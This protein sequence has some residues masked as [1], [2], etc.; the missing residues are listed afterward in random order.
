MDL[1]KLGQK[2]YCLV[3]PVNIG[4]YIIENNDVCL[5]DTGNSEDFAKLIDKVLIDNNW[6][7]KYIINTHSHADHIG[8]NKYLQTKY[9]CE[10]FANLKES[11]FINETILE[12]ILLYNTNP[13]KEM[14]NN[15]LKADDSVC[16][17]IEGTNIDGLKI[18]NLEGHSIGQVGVLTSDGV[19]FCGDAYTSTNII[20]KYPIQYVYDIENYLKSLM[21]LRQT[22]YQYYV[23]SHGEIEKNNKNTI[24]DNINNINNL[25]NEI[26][27]LLKN[28][29]TYPRLLSA[30]FAK[31]NIKLNLIQYHLLSATIKSF[32]TKLEKEGKVK[33]V[34]DNNEFAILIIENM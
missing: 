21:F 19:C 31:H 32:L 1:I 23:P 25:E 14:L 27:E 10:I 4:I 5:I 15:L 9:N 34:F 24:T 20:K 2:T 26:Y 16:K 3:S 17:K 22:N 8:G 33:F 28:N 11:Y 6:N 12:P 18:I 7:L 30:I 29:K 13:P